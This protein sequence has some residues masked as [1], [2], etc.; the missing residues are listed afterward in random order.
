MV[1]DLT[2]DHVGH[3]GDGVALVDAQAVYVPYTL[4]GEAVEVEAVADQPDRRR[5]LRIESA[6]KQRI[7][8]FCPHFATCG[9]CAIQHWQL[10]PYRAW[11][12]NIVVETLAQARQRPAAGF[13][14]G[15]PLT[16]EGLEPIGQ[17]RT[18]GAS[19]V[20]GQHAG[21]SQETSVELQ[22]DICLHG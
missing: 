9:G 2:I 17:E 21:L 3:R 16:N 8:P 1:E 18:D 6:S 4:S 19:L 22:S 5:L 14:E 12:R 7:A 11:K 15:L 13:V 10:E 20:S